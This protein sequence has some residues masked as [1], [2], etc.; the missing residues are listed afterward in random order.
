MEEDLCELTAYLVM[1][2]IMDNEFLVERLFKG[3]HDPILLHLRSLR[4]S[5]ETQISSS[6]WEDLIS[7]LLQNSRNIQDLISFARE[8]KTLT[9]FKMS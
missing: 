1:L 3:K 9:G 6:S 5:V 8:H 4:R 2:T 7:P